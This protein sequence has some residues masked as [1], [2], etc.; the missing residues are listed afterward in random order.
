MK[1]RH[2]Y[3]EIR[4]MNIDDLGPVFHL[5]ERLFTS[6]R[7]PNLYRMWDE[8]EVTGTFQQDSEFC[9]VAETEDRIVGFTLGTTIRKPRSPWKYGHLI[10]L[11]VDPDC[12]RARIATRLFNH[13]REKMEEHGVRILLI[14]TDAENL[15]AIRFFQRMGFIHP[16]NHIYMTFNLETG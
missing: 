2:Q 6:Q 14:D 3:I 16:R 11:G 7:V 10:W 9:F 5:G 8:F 4:D 1:N 12:Q 15:P 13:F